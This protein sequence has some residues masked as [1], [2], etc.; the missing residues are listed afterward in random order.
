MT[1]WQ[2][3]G[4]VMLAGP[5]PGFLVTREVRRCGWRSAAVGM[6]MAAAAIAL[7]CLAVVYVRVGL[8]LLAGELP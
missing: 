4:G 8:G 2:I 6:L 5:L 7:F 3:L 1:G